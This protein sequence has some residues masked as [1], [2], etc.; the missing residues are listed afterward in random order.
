MTSRKRVKEDTIPQIARR[1][2]LLR[3][4]KAGDD[5]GDQA[6]FCREIGVMPQSSNGYELE[7]NGRIG[8]DM[9][10]KLVDRWNVTLDWIYLGDKR[11]MPHS[12]MIEIERAEAQHK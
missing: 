9:A 11:A 12:L 2:R 1:L 6:A 7:R 4:A 3:I 8:L 5:R 10:L